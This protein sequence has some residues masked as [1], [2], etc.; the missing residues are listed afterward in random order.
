[1]QVE[2][3]KRYS[4]GF[5]TIKVKEVRDDLLI[6]DDTGTWVAVVVCDTPSTSKDVVLSITD[7]QDHFV[8]VA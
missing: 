3:G 2:V 7:I 1:M 8:E 4:Y 5:L 6:K